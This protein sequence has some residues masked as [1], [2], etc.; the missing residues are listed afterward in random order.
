MPPKP[1]KKIDGVMPGG[2]RMR[3]R[4]AM[5]KEN[6]VLRLGDFPVSTATLAAGIFLGGCRKK[7]GWS[8]RRTGRELGISFTAWRNIELGI[9]PP[10]R[11]TLLKLLYN[12][13]LTSKER[14]SLTRAYYE[15]DVLGGIS[16]LTATDLLEGEMDA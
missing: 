3:G 14:A 11:T 7:L 15:H 9:K 6:K 13:G 4:S 12:I 5:K 10:G 8:M 16:N 1:P 2:Y